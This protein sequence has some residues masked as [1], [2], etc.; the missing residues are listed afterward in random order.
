[1]VEERG[2][3]VDRR[4]LPFAYLAFMLNTNA[5]FLSLLRSFVCGASL[6]GMLTAFS[7]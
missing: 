7:P 2:L 4:F 6:A 1:M 3:L 5:R